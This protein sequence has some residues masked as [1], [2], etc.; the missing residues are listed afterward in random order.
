MEAILDAME[1]SQRQT[2][3]WQATNWLL[4]NVGTTA[5]QWIQHMLPY[6]MG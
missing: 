4:A 1:I 3:T 6:P 2:F 5:T